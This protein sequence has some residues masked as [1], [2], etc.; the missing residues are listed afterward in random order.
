M[1]LNKKN[2][3]LQLIETI[4]D[5]LVYIKSNYGEKMQTMVFDCV[6]ALK[7]IR[8]KLDEENNKTLNIVNELVNYLNE[9]LN[10]LNEDKK[11]KKNI[12]LIIK[13][14]LDLKCS[15]KNDIDTEI[16]IAFMPYKISMWDCMESV[17][18]EAK[19]DPNC[20]C[21]VIPIPYYEFNRSG[22]VE[23]ICYEGSE[24]PDYI[25]ITPF[26][27]Y[28]LEN[29]RPDIIYIHNPYDD[30][31]TLTMIP[32][33]Y[34]SKNMLDYT[35]MLVYIPYFVA[36]SYKN[37][38]SHEN[39][40][41]LPGPLNANKIIVQ[42]KVQKE[43]FISNG[44]NP[45]KI[46]DLGSPK[47]DCA[48]LNLNKEYEIPVE[49]R[50][51]ISNKKVFLLSTGITNLLSDENWTNDLM[52]V[53][54]VFEDHNECCLIWRQHPLTEV[55]INRMRPNLVDDFNKIKN[56]IDSS[57]N[58]I[59]DT[60][61]DIYTTMCISDALISDY[62]SILFQYMVTGKPILGMFEKELLE[63]DRIYAIDY[64]CNYFKNRDMEI[65]DFR[66]MILDDN[67]TKREQRINSLRNSI[68]NIDG[69]CGEKI[70]EYIK[71]EVLNSI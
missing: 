66:D 35:N 25:E 47:F 30:C 56:K 34:F 61:S 18:K 4:S 1:R 27:L 57:K 37:L 52:D 20:S 21:Y 14:N 49:W 10:L 65:I 28:D 17:W 42:S 41:L 38:K 70:H 6:E 13:K 15:I 43:L 7:Y 69:T 12:E 59:I 24:F 55:T 40:S 5:A 26:N 32:E 22:E 67:D 2:D 54:N 58:I 16:E 19:S 60:S 45:N 33:K 44:H 53:I 63:K 68:T 71:T 64:L 48:I 29:R 31:N 3:I 50:N 11:G 8:T 36:G 46:A 23:K 51:I 9:T 39:M 62:S